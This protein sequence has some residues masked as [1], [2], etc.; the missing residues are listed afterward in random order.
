[1]FRTSIFTSAFV[2]FALGVMATGSA[3]T[4]ASAFSSQVYGARNQQVHGTDH[5]TLLLQFDAD[6]RRFPGRLV[7][8][9][10]L[11]K[12][13]QEFGNDFP[14]P[15]RAG[16][17]G[18]VLEFVGRDR[19][20]PDLLRRARVQF[21]DDRLQPLQI[22]DEDVGVEEHHASGSRGRSLP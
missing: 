11:H 21:A 3:V 16:F 14:P 7:V 17:E 15:C 19:R 1:M 6:P 18:A 22:V 2:A 8:E 9:R 10:K 12:A 4:P 20:N 5:E 13:C